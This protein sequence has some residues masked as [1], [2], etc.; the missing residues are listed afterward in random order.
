MALPTPHLD[1]INAAIA[2]DKMPQRA[3]EELTALLPVYRKWISDMA[4]VSGERDQVLRELV[5]LSN[6]YKF[7]VDFNLIFSS[8]EDFLYRQKGRLKLDNKVDLL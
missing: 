1:K 3:I 6:G 8:T 2:N 7:H 5:S 4:A